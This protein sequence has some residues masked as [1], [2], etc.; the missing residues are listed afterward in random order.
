MRWFTA[1]KLTVCVFG[2]AAVACASDIESYCEDKIDCEGGTDRHIDEC[3][4]DLEDDED[5]AYRLGCEDYWDD[6]MA[7]RDETG[8]CRGADWDTDCG[9]EKKRLESCEGG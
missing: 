7:C 9:P 8:V 2:L 1:A 3:I 6:Y 4:F 5:K